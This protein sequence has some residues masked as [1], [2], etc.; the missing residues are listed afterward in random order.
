M[1]ILKQLSWAAFIAALA[2]W[3]TAAITADLTFV[4]SAVCFLAV[5]MGFAA[6]RHG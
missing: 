5:A 1:D 2:M 3:V 6:A 4:A